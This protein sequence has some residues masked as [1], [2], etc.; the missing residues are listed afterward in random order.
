MR[1]SRMASRPKSLICPLCGSGELRAVGHDSARCAS[2]SAFIQGWTLE[3]LCQVAALPDALGG[4]AC[5]CGHPEMRRLSRGG[6]PL[7]CLW[8]GGTPLDTSLTARSKTAGQDFQ[9]WSR[10]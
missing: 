3:F 4:H 10:R 7:P 2:C 1:R 6:V 8:L 5:E 9:R